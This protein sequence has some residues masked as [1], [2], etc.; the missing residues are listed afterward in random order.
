MTAT[1]IKKGF[2]VNV[3]EGAGTGAKFRDFEY[4]SA[5][6]KLVKKEDAFHSGVNLLILLFEHIVVTKLFC[7]IYFDRTL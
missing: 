5:G 7:I 2:S 6:A 3:E 4:Q 1:L